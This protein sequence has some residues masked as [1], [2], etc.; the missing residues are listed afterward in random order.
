MLQH[1]RFVD[2]LRRVGKIPLVRVPGVTIKMELEAAKR[3]EAA[4]K[5][6][7][8]DLILEKATEAEHPGGSAYML[9]QITPD[10]QE[11]WREGLIPL[12]FPIC[13]YECNIGNGRAGF[14]IYEEGPLWGVERY[15]MTTSYGRL[16]LLFDGCN[17]L[18]DRT[19]P[20]RENGDLPM[21]LGGNPTVVRMVQMEE[22]T[23]SMNWSAAG[24]LAIYLTLMLNSRSTES[25]REV[26]PPKLNKAKG[27]RGRALLAPHTVVHIV[28]Q[29][30]RSEHDPATGKTH[31]SPR[32]HWRRSHVRTYETGKKVVIARMLVGKAELGTL[33]HE[34]RISSKS[35]PQGE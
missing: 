18:V 28:P 9:P 30:Y 10:E 35:Q 20:V 5:F 1:H 16:E 24:C 33:S 29:R 15:D 12:P 27:K 22:L 32:L 6:D 11:F 7:F 34:Y 13:W 23:Q 4:M 21:K 26:P 25:R 17:V 2:A 14:L 8:G 31:A 19:D 3:I